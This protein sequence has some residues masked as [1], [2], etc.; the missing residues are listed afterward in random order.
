MNPSDIRPATRE[1]Y[2][3]RQT[4]RAQQRKG[5]AHFI[6]DMEALERTGEAT[7]LTMEPVG[8]VSQAFIRD[9][10]FVT[11]IMGPYGSAKTTSCFQKIL[12]ICLW[13]NEGRDGVKRAR[14]CVTRPTYGQLQ[15][16]V[17]KDWFSWF[18]QTRENWNGE[19]MDHK[20]R[21]SIPGLAEIELEMCFRAV[22]D[23]GKAEKVFKGM[24][25]TFLWPNE[26]DTQH[27][28][29][30]EYGMPRLGRYPSANMGGCAWSGVIADLNAP[31]ID[32][33]VVPLLVDGDMGL[34]EEQIEKFLALYGEDFGVGFHRQPGGDE[35]NAENL[36]NL[37][38]GYYD[39]LRIGKSENYIRRFIK[40]LFGAVRNGQPVYPEFNDEFHVAKEALTPVPGVPVCLA[41]DGGSTPAAVFGQKLS[42]GQIRV[43]DELVVMAPDENTALEKLGPESFGEE[44]AE[45]WMEHYANCQFGGGWSDP[46][47]FDGDEY[48]A[49]WSTR[50]WNA[51]KA[52]MAELGRKDAKRWKL[53][54]APVPGN[55]IP[56]RIE[57]VRGT[58]TRN[59]GGQPGMLV[60]PRARW[61]RRG[62]NNGYVIVR[63]A[64]SNGHGRWK[65]EPLK[66]DFSHVHDALQYLV[67]GLVKVGAALLARADNDHGRRVERKRVK[68]GGAFAPRSR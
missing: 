19:K 34:S 65:D 36:H 58:L 42:G 51:F 10:R 54:A 27:P 6:A 37:P 60:S 44:C 25:L 29:V 8:P 59:P 56:D 21:I 41:V 35:P 45:F 68:F 3:S 23:A 40:N 17:M 7:A 49:S 26:I 61:L 52:R 48:T 14:G 15:D 53:K 5:A 22:D 31:D 66:N 57:P 39:R 9:R 62:F 30:L 24:Q 1:D 32:N 13:Q 12:N 20:V 64:M 28:A 4:Y 50:F 18:P 38:E 33:W 2:P 11:A 43:L 55:R 46:A 63:T 16:T 47:G 67:V